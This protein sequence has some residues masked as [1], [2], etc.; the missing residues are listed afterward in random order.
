[1]PKISHH[2]SDIQS[3]RAIAVMLVIAGHLFPSVVKGGFI[4]VDLFFV[5]SGFV[6]T[7][8]M[9]TLYEANPATFLRAF[10]SKR[11]KRILP[12]ALLVTVVSIFASTYLLGPVAGNDAKVDGSWTTIFLGNFH[13]H[14]I[15]LN[16]FETGTQQSPLQHYWSLSIEE[17]FYLI[18]PALFLILTIKAQSLRAKQ[19]IL[20]GITLS[21]LFTALYLAEIKS[22]PIFF[23]SATRVWELAL[24]ALLAISAVSI[25]VPKNLTYLSLGILL[26][27][28]ILIM[29]TMQWPGLLSIP[30]ALAASVLLVNNPRLGQIRLFNNRLLVYVGNLSYL[31][32]LWHWPIYI[33]TKALS[34]PFGNIEK[35]YV[36]I[37]T[38]FL[39]IIT[40]HFFENPIRFSTTGKPRTT[41]ALGVSAIAALSS[42]LFIS[43]QG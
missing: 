19:L 13:F 28:S 35:L 2:R 8:Q 42:F 43:H 23:L 11:V 14:E 24:G 34:T 26:L 33:I 25:R 27:S 17:Q 6:I 32:Y 20:L 30:I 39:S 15:A 40:H 38:V 18:W 31:L 3:L 37:L 41:I 7:I 5:I 16:Y 21:S 12:A 1:M 4:G 36:L 29:P 10:Y 9:T 22:A